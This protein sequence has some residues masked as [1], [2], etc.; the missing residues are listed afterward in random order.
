MKYEVASQE[1]HFASEEQDLEAGHQPEDNQ[2]DLGVF[3][4]HDQIRM[5]A[6]CGLVLQNSALTLT[7]K[8][9]S[10]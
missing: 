4:D 1:E 2:Q 10:I 5:L 3:R 7:I 6:L 8:Q 9:A